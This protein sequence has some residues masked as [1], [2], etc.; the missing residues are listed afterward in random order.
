MHVCTYIY[1][2]VVGQALRRRAHLPLTRQSAKTAIIFEIENKFAP[3][4]F[5]EVFL[6]PLLLQF[7]RILCTYTISGRGQG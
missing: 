5:L 6:R 3:K 1:V 7:D 4:L 2:A